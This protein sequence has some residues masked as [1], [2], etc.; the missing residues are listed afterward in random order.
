[1]AHTVATRI[2]EFNFNLADVIKLLQ[3]AN[4]G[5][6]DIQAMPP[7][8]KGCVFSSNPLGLKIIRTVTGVKTGE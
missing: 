2:T 7:D 3:D 6:L 8:G 4:P 1:M 5:D